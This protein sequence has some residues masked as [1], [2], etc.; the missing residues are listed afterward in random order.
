MIKTKFTC[1]NPGCFISHWVDIPDLE[2]LPVAVLA[3][4]CMVD[5][6]VVGIERLNDVWR[7]KVK[8]GQSIIENGL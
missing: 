5:H 3:P 8:A 2:N 1:R 4:C 6:Y 7:L